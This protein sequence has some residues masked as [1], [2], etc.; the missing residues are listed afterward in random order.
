MDKKNYSVL[1]RLAI[2]NE[3]AGREYC[4][5]EQDK[6]LLQSMLEKINSHIG[7]DFHYLA[8]LDMYCLHGIKEIVSRYINSFESESVKAYLLHHLTVD[9]G[10]EYAQLI[11]QLFIHFKASDEYIA[12][13]GK[14]SPA[15]IYVRYDNAFRRLKP[16]RLK[17]ELLAL[18]RDPLD[19]FYLPFTMRMLASWKLPEMEE[20]LLSYLDEC[21][22]TGET[23]RLVPGDEK[24]DDHLKFSRREL[25]FTAI[26]GLRYYPSEENIEIIKSFKNNVDDDISC[27][28]KETLRYLEK[29]ALV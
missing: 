13:Q 20:I 14:P 17:A 2:E 6:E 1:L 19:A 12:I 23:L 9:G 21:R 8:E 3:L 24:Y 11:Y 22:I 7:S 16:K 15:H 27:A 5:S 28:A 10:K 26:H 25:K 29:R 4:Y 18:S